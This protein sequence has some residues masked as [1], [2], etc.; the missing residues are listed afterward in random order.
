MHLLKAATGSCFTYISVVGST[1]ISSGIKCCVT[2]Y[3]FW[4]DVWWVRITKLLSDIVIDNRLGFSAKAFCRLFNYMTISV[5][6][7]AIVIAQWTVISAA[8]NS[9]ACISIMHRHTHPFNGLYLGLR[10]WVGTR[11]VKLIWI[12]LKQ[13]TVSGSGISWVICKSAPHFRQIITPASHH[14]VFYRPDVLPAT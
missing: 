13:E 11:K 10:K 12:L 6:R 8:C 9:H 1:D 7:V 5:R 3:H 14:S 4:A 2:Q